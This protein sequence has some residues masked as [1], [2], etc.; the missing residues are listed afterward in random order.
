MRQMQSL[1]KH[2]RPCHKNKTRHKKNR[3]TNFKFYRPILYIHIILIPIMI[4]SVY[5]KNASLLHS[6][7]QRLDL[8]LSAS[9]NPSPIKLIHK[10]VVVIANA[11]GIQ[12]HGFPRKIS[13]S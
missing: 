8:G 13:P 10:I 12:I 6:N 7:H 2:I 11:G 9:L 1:T 4:R 5:V 3:P